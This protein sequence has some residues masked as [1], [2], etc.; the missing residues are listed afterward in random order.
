MRFSHLKAAAVLLSSMSLCAQQPAST[1]P[2]APAEPETEEAQGP[3]AAAISALE[4][5]GIS[6]RQFNST[7]VA[8]AYSGDAITMQTLLDA[9]ADVNARDY[10]TRGTALHAAAQEGHESCL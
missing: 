8:T 5:A 1:P 7:L 10:R 9:G 3:D 6:R 4:Q 2:A